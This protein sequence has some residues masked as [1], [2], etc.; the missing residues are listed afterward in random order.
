MTNNLILYMHTV[1]YLAAVNSKA[2]V[3]LFLIHCFMYNVPHIVCGGSVLVF[4]CYALLCALSSFAI[5]LMRKRWLAA[6]L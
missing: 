5:I 3:L 2:E 6:L 1:C 4:V